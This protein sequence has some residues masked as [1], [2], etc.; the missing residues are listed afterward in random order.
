MQIF[1]NNAESTLAVSINS[2]DV[3]PMNVQ[4]T[5]G[6]GDRFPLVS[7]IGADYFDITLESAAGL[8]EIFR[9]KQRTAGSDVMVVDSRAR[10]STAAQ[11]WTTSPATVVGLRM[12]AAA[13]ETVLAHPAVS[14]GAHAAT[15][16][17]N[18]PTGGIA[19][20]TVQAAI[21]ELDTDKEAAGVAAGLIAAHEVAA[22]PHPDYTTTAELAAGLATK[23]NSDPLL[24]ALAAQTTAANRLQ[25]YSN[26]DTP[27]LYTVGV[28]SG[29]IPVV[30]ATSTASTSLAG[31]AKKAVAGSIAAGTADLYPDAALVKTAITAAA[32]GVISYTGTGGIAS[33]GARITS[34]ASF[35]LDNTIPQITEGLALLDV[36][37]T[38]SRVG[39][40]IEIEAVMNIDNG[41]SGLVI[42]AIF[43]AGGANAV[44]LALFQTPALANSAMP[45]RCVHRYTA[46]GTTPVVFNLRGG[47]FPGGF[48]CV[49]NAGDA[50]YTLGDL[51]LGYIVARE[52]A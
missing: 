46:V 25:G 7:T 10:E 30:G 34:T 35:P 45:V 39:A 12:T 1:K 24:T 50:A 23:Q 11:N 9:I 21:N 51:F 22:N 52:V 15:A 47:A 3:V 48:N 27:L 36:T 40:V 17:S 20:T 44:S 16:I 2:T 13:V 41:T 26:V 19:A 18:A 42:L 38:P 49:Y 6:H 37:F 33:P 43:A 28:D 14:V 31:L 5:A 32:G 29:N 8:V 4:V